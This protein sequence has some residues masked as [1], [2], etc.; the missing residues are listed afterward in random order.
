MPPVQAR[1]LGEHSTSGPQCLSHADPVGTGQLQAVLQANPLANSKALILQLLKW[2]LI[3]IW[4]SI[5]D[6]V[7]SSV[8]AIG[9]PKSHYVKVIKL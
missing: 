7:Q 5:Q 1:H 2:Y 4:K 8:T 3:F 9:L 6:T